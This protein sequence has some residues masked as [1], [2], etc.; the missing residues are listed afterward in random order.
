MILRI[1]KSKLPV[2]LI[3]FLIAALFTLPSCAHGQVSAFEVPSKQSFGS[4]NG[5]IVGTVYLNR[6]GA[7]AP[8]VIVSI[9]STESGRFQTV[10]TDLGGHF[11]L[12]GIPSG[13]YEVSV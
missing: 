3:S 9:H 5:Q 12:C 7:P 11:E 6:G 8:H 1:C 10:L 2:V 13:S 4:R